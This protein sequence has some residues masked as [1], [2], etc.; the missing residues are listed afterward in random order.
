MLRLWLSVPSWP[1]LP[2]NLGM[3]TIADHACWL[4]QRRPLME[5]PSQFLVEMTRRK[6]EQAA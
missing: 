2:A 5:L 3:H 4:R 1:A 6:A